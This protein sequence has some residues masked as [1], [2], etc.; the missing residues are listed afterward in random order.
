MHR[1]PS[2]LVMMCKG[3]GQGLKAFW[4][5]SIASISLNTFLA[6]ASLSGARRRNLESTGL[7]DVRMKW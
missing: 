5:R 1:V 3:D 7:P 6:V 2:F 4:Q